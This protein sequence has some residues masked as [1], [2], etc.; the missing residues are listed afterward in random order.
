MYGYLIL[1]VVY[2]TIPWPDSGTRDTEFQ[3]VGLKRLAGSRSA[4]KRLHLEEAL[5]LESD[6]VPDHPILGPL[7]LPKAPFLFLPSGIPDSGNPQETT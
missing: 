5:M 6:R 1:L 3:V 7:W 4:T 2:T